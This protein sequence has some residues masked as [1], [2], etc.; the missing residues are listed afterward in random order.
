[1]RIFAGAFKPHTKIRCPPHG[2]GGKISPQMQRNLSARPLPKIL[3]SAYFYYAAARELPAGNS[4]KPHFAA[5]EITACR[6]FSR[7]GGSV[8]KIVRRTWRFC[9][10]KSAKPPPNGKLNLAV[11]CAETASVKSLRKYR[12]TFNTDCRQIAKHLIPSARL[13]IIAELLNTKY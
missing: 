4:Q 1:M 5:F 2:S 8:I 11:R 6:Y 9:G 13:L 7:A 10:L 3:S 12:Q